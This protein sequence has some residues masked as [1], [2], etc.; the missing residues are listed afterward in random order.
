M[1]KQLIS[2]GR[3]LGG[4]AVEIIGKGA[5]VPAGALAL[6]SEGGFLEKIQDAYLKLSLLPT[7][8][9][10]RGKQIVEMRAD[11][12][13][14]MGIRDF[15]EKYGVDTVPEATLDAVNEGV[16]YATNVYEN[17]I[18]APVETGL[19]G[20]AALGL[21]WVA[22]EIGNFVRTKGQGGLATRLKRSAGKKVFRS[23]E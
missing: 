21:A 5:A 8:V 10:S 7:E 22:G 11:Y 17:M 4:G 23:K 13:D 9:F 16:N 18:N 19:A 12:N 20:V 1:K 3:Y 14:N 6:G 2:A 15:S